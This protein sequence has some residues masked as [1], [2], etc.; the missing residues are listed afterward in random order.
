MIQGFLVQAMLREYLRPQRVF[1]WLAVVLILFGVSKVFLY[2]NPR[3]EPGTA[4][5]DLSGWLVY[6]V[7]ALAAA[8]LSASVL[9]QEVEQ[10]TIVYLV[11][12]PIPRTTLLLSR[13]TA[14]VLAVVAIGFACAISV[15]FATHGGQALANGYLWRDFKGLTVG[16]VAYSLLFVLVSL[17]ISRAMIVN[18]LFAFGWEIMI[19]NMSGNVYWLS[20]H[21]YLK[22]IA[23]RPITSGGGP[24]AFLSGDQ[25]LESISSSTAWVVMVVG[26]AAMGFLCVWWFGKFP[27]LPREDAD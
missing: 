4:Y 26:I 23:E 10:K 2:V 21:S 16:A 15:S 7:M 19:P 24:M 11:T 14:L 3:I 5:V 12:R 6:K 17:W 22:A 9:S 18:L 25:S 8:I 27:Y 1:A 20:I 13:V